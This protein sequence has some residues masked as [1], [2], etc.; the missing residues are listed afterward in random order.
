[1]DV[2]R[3]GPAVP[4]AVVHAGADRWRPTRRTTTSSTPASE[5]E[6]GRPLRT[7][8]GL[9]VAR[10]ARRVVRREVRL[11][12]GQ[13]L[14]EQRRGS[15]TSRCGRA[16]GPGR[17]WSPAIGAEHAATREA[18]GAVRRV[19]VRQAE[20]TGPGR[21][22]AAR[23]GLRQPRWPA[24]SA[25]SPTPR[26]STRAAGSSR[27]SPSPGSATTRSWSSP[28]RRSATHDLA[29]LRRQARR[30]DGR[31]ARRRRHRR[32]RSRYALWGPRSRDDAARR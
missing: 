32:A 18:G 28:A 11:G 21:R 8:P 26:R 10:R 29:W 25:T 19:V 3:F 13:L 31:R 30:R 24:A 14:R 5:R 1:M 23:V 7:T 22:R 17:H 15:A 4:L 9:P 12:A 16:A 2:R 20:V 6:A 27:T